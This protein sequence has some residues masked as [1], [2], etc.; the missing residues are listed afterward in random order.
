MQ[1][2]SVSIKQCL[3]SMAADCIFHF[4]TTQINRKG[5]R[6]YICVRSGGTSS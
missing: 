2:F 4:I 1:S 6:S 3:Q 5:S